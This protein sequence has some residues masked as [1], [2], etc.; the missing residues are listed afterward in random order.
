MK[1][2]QNFKKNE[3]RY[4]NLVLLGVEN[5]KKSKNKNEF[6]APPKV[7]ERKKYYNKKSRVGYLYYKPISK[8]L[9]FN[10]EG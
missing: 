3:L 4:F 2:R 1:F 10:D 9:T 7:M 6:L 8:I 5:I